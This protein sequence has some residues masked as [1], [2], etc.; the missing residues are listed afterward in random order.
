MDIFC[1]CVFGFLTLLVEV[2]AKKKTPGRKFRPAF[3]T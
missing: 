3:L 1:L 2:R